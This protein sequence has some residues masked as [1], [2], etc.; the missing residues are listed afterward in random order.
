MNPAVTDLAALIVTVQVPVPEQP[1]PLQPVKFASKS[2]CAVRTTTVFK[3][4]AFVQLSPQFIFAGLLVTVPVPVPL[5][6]RVRTRPAV[7]LAERDLGDVIVKTQ[8]LIP[9]VEQAP[10]Q[11]DKA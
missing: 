11:L 3:G 9:K 5:M 4:K 8:S 7:K 10:P 6:V 1:L 2:G